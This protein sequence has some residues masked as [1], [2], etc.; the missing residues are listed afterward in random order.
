[1]AQKVEFREKGIS[2]LQLDQKIEELEIDAFDK[3]ENHKGIKTGYQGGFT[4]I[5]DYYF[6]KGDSMYIEGCAVIKDIFFAANKNGRIRGV[7]LS[8]DCY[9]ENLVLQLQN[10]FGA[11]LSQSSS[12]IGSYFKTSKLFFKKNEID[13]FLITYDGEQISKIMICNTSFDEKSPGLDF[14]FMYKESY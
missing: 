4:T 1:M 7:F 12:G 5:Y 14:R 10:V 2:I 6:I 8:F 9:C 3:I 13:V 11:P